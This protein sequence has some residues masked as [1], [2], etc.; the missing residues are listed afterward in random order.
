[1]N[2]WRYRGKFAS[3]SSRSFSLVTEPQINAQMDMYRLVGSYSVPKP[4]INFV[5]AYEHN[6]N[7]KVG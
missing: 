3:W 2:A 7:L 6:T 1:M 5:R 4:R